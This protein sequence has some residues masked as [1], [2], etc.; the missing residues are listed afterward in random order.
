MQKPISYEWL[1]ET[2][3]FRSILLKTTLQTLNEDLKPTVASFNVLFSSNTNQ[4]QNKITF[5]ILRSVVRVVFS[6]NF[7]DAYNRITFQTFWKQC[8]PYIL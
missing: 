2:V 5:V 4:H 6:I 7:E 1:M 3:I 8:S